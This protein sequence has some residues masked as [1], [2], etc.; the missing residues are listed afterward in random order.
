MQYPVDLEKIRDVLP[1]SYER[2]WDTIM[3]LTIFSVDLYMD[4][5]I[6][7]KKLRVGVFGPYTEKGKRV[8]KIIGNTVCKNGNIAVTG[9]G[10]YI[11]DKC[12]IIPS[13]EFFPPIIDEVVTKFKIPDYVKYHHFPRLV[14]RAVNLLSPTRAQGNEAEGCSRFGIPMI[15]I[16]IDPRVGTEEKDVCNYIEDFE[17][18]QECMCPEKDLCLYRELEP[19]CPFYDYVNVPWAIKQLFLTKINR[20]VA[21]PDSS[22]VDFT[23]T[24]YLKSKMTKPSFWEDS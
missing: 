16:I 12:E 20:L 11:P 5:K 1:D 22:A 7:P 21:L 2:F 3:N 10:A 4:K 19:K 24:E 17:I 15:G 18:Y 8:L 13:K 9:Y 14:I 23:V 6:G